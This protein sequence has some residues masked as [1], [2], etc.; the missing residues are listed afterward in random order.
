MTPVDL[1][2]LVATLDPHGSGGRRHADALGAAI[3]AQNPDIEASALPELVHDTIERGQRE[4]LWSASR[5][6]TV[7]RGRTV[8]P[9]TITLTAP[10]HPTDRTQ[11]VDAPLRPE[12]HWASTLRLSTSQREVLLAANDWLRRTDGGKAPVV[13]VAERAYELL[14]QEKAFDGNP[15]RGGTTL[16]APHRLT[17]K[18]LRC[19]R[20]P[21]P[22]LWEPVTPEVRHPGAVIFLENHA[23]F[24][25]MLRLLRTETAPSWAA[26]AWVQ[27]RNTAPLTS[28][29]RLPFPI[30]HLDYLGD[31]DA[32]GLQIAKAACD[33]VER[34]GIPARPAERLWRLL[35]IQPPRLAHPLPDAEARRLTMW[36]PAA[37]RN[38]A[39]KLLVSGYAVPQEA[40]RFDVLSQARWY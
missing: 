3:R 19:E 38:Q 34:S 18:L 36:L 1:A 12:L 23:T 22:L 10:G 11:R 16:W 17:F 14:R 5:S 28:L 32:A 13:S 31:M 39:R 6:T 21:T 2:A 33:C 27:G 37:L 24:R 29:A 15:P 4:G 7:R 40:L 35:V 25:T 9:K 30:T 8:L 20:P 26:V